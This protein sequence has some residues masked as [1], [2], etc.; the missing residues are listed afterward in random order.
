M[1]KFKLGGREFNSRFIMG[2]GKFDPNLIQAC[3]NE[4]EV[5]IVTMALRRVHDKNENITNFIPKNIT[6]LPNTSGARNADEALRI[7]RL[8]REL[9]CGEFIKIE[10][11]RESKYLFPDNYESTKATE[12][13]AKD[14]FIPLVYMYPDLNTAR[15]L[16]NAG[17]AAIMPLAA[18][19]GSNKGMINREIIQILIDE[20]KAPIIVDAGLGRPSEACLAMEMGCAAVM[21]NTAIATAND[22]KGMAKAF[23]GAIKAGRIAYLSGLGRVR[24]TAQASSPLT[25]FLE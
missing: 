11:I 6:L 23:A 21:A 14:G 24:D 19:I 10:V 18:P 20:I 3:I 1:D 7:A 25:G 13:L 2:S 22:V 8:A 15:D 5:E 12:L 4:G 16:L 9:G 17:A